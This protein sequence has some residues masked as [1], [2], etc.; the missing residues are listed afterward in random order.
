VLLL[1]ESAA[2]DSAGDVTPTSVQS[3]AVTKSYIRM[4]MF[5]L[6]LLVRR[7]YV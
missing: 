7:F 5:F 1:L 2:L 4:G 6:C 3:I